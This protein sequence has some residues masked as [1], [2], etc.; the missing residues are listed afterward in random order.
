MSFLRKNKKMLQ[1]AA[2]GS[3]VGM[4]FLGAIFGGKKKKRKAAKLAAQRH[5]EAELRKQQ[6]DEIAR[7]SAG[8]PTPANPAMTQH[9]A[10]NATPTPSMV[11]QGYYDAANVYV[12][13]ATPR[14]Y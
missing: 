11:A 1:G 10:K 5:Y 14:S 2:L 7:K 6:A 4:P 8:V 3:I 13:P 9:L 12:P